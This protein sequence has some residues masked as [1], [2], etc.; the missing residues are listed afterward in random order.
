MLGGLNFSSK[1]EVLDYIKEQPFMITGESWSLFGLTFY[2]HPG[3]DV[4]HPVPV[5]AKT[6][7][8]GIV[9]SYNEGT[10]RYTALTDILQ[11]Q[12]EI[13][14]FLQKMME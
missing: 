12:V 5:V 10:M 9:F 14:E 6:S 3:D 13:I 8:M 1:S 7:V 11:P 4:S 2:K